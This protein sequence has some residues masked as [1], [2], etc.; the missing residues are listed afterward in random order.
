VK[1]KDADRKS[2]QGFG[3]FGQSDPP[4]GAVKEFVA[5]MILQ[6]TNLGTD[7]RLCQSEPFGGMSETVAFGY[8]SKCSQE[9]Y[10]NVTHMHDK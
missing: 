7:R 5:E 6:A 1:L 8:S 4:V 2:H 9:T 10:I 3:G